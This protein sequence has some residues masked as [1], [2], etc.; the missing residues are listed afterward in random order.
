[1]VT[2]CAGWVEPLNLECILVNTLAGSMEIFVFLALIFIAMVG[3]RFRMINMTLLIMFGL[4]GVLMAQYMS[5]IYFLTIMIAGLVIAF[6]IGRIIK[7]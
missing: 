5:G 1:M 2:S 7:T 4:F 6:G 3:A